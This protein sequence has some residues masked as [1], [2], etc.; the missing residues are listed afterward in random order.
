MNQKTPH[1]KDIKLNDS[2]S[3]NYREQECP[4]GF[5]QPKL[6][7]LT[8]DLRPS[9]QDAELL[10]S[11][12]K[13]MSQLEDDVNL[14]FFIGHKKV[15]SFLSIS[16]IQIWFTALILKCVLLHN[17]NKYASIPIAYVENIKTILNKIKYNEHNWFI[18]VDLKLVNF[19]LGFQSG[20]T[21]YPSFLCLWDSRARQIH[22]KTNKW[23]LRDELTVGKANV[24]S[25]PLVSGGGII[26]P[27]LHIKLGLCKQFVKAL[28]KDGECFKY[29]CL[30][31]PDISLEK[32]KAGVLTD[33]KSGGSSLGVNMSIKVHYLHS[34]LDKFPDNL[35]AYSDEQGER[36]YQDMKVMEERYQGVCHM[37]A[38]YCWNLSRDLPEYTYKRKS[39]RLKFMKD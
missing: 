26:L 19:L 23:P 9:K 6:N 15:R 10:A 39:K 17:G 8:R 13:E 4:K 37:M 36:F 16:K 34:H 21:K 1:K 32:I 27:P 25:K 11:R 30:F 24:I 35:G 33:L 28:D 31:F 18:C 38:D 3:E 12:L 14:T 7:Y 22:W 20:Y 29:M 5:S 2:D